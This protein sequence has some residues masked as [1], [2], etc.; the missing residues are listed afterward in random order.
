MHKSNQ[1]QTPKLMAVSTVVG[2]VASTSAASSV[3][4]S[5]GVVNLKEVSHKALAGG[6]ITCVEFSGVLLD[7][8]GVAGE[9]PAV[10]GGHFTA[11]E[12]AINDAGDL[13]VVTGNLDIAAGAAISFSDLS[14]SPAPFAP[15]TILTLVNYGGAWNGGVFS[16]NG[17]PLDQGGEF[18]LGGTIWG[19]DYTAA[20]GG[21]NFQEDQI[22]GSFV[23]I[24][25]VPEPSTIARL[26]LGALAWFFVSARKTR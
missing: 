4:V 12:D 3:G 6:F 10:C 19:I 2:V 1:M 13:L 26:G 23:N 17:T 7:A 18:T 21:S 5:K 15:G 24:T 16:L 14:Q 20:T 22:A 9:E 8:W 25:A 11:F